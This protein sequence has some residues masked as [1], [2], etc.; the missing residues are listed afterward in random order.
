MRLGFFSFL[1]LV[2]F[3]MLYLQHGQI[4]QSIVHVE[5]TAMLYFSTRP[6]VN[7]NVR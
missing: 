2:D 7:S 3:D 5:P 1:Y 6:N 4:R